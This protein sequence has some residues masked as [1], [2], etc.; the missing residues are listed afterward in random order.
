[1][2]QAKPKTAKAADADTVLRLRRTFAAPREAVWRAF[3]VAEELKRW[4]GPRG[5]TCPVAELDVRP[6]GRYRTEMRA[7]DGGVYVTTGEFREVAPPERLVLTWVWGEGEMAGH[8]TLLTIELEDRG[9]ATELTLTH[10]R[11]P[12]AAKRDLHDQGWSSSL[13]CLA[14]ALEQSAEQIS[15]EKD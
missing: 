5:M 6:G 13:D 12:D 15:E 14:E 1:M 7:P 10:E 8:E 11:F 2:A 9:G 4:W 3:T